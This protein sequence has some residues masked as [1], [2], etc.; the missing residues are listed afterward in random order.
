[1]SAAMAPKL[2]HAASLFI[3][4]NAGDLTIGYR[5]L[6]INGVPR[7]DHYDKN[8]N[9]LLRD[10]QYELKTPVA[11]IH[12]DGSPFLAI[13]TG[14]PEPTSE[15]RLMPHV[16][17]LVPEPFE[18]LLNLGK[19]D[20]ADRAIGVSFLQWAVRGTLFTDRRLW[21]Q[22]RG[23]YS[24]TPLPAPDSSD[25]DIYP[26]FIWNVVLLD[27]TRLALTIDVTSRFV[28]RSWVTERISRRESL[29]GRNCLYQFG[30]QWYLIQVRAVLDTSI[31]TYQIWPE[32]SPHAIGLFQ[33]VHERWRSNPP[34]WIQHLDPKSPTLLFR[35][36]ADQERAAPAGLCK[37][38]LPT[39]DPNAGR[40]L[41]R[42]I[43]SPAE[44]FVRIQQVLIDHL[45]RL[46]L[47]NRAVSLDGPECVAGRY[48]SI[49][50]HR[51]GGNYVMQVD[52]GEP[53]SAAT[54][55]QT[56]N[57]YARRRLQIARNP[58]V[59]PVDRTP[60]G[61]QYLFLPESLPRQINEDFAGR[62]E[63]AVGQIAGEKYRPTRVLY[64]DPGTASLSRQVAAIR[65]AIASS[66]AAHGYALVVLPLNAHPDLH[67]YLKR[68]LWPGL[69]LQCAMAGKIRSHYSQ[70]GSEWV[71]NQM[72][73]LESYVLNCALGLM[74]VNRKWLW[75]LDTPLHY[76][77]YIGIDVL[78][79][80]VGLTFL[81]S[82]GQHVVFSNH[83]AK[84]K[85]RLSSRQIRGLIR[86]RLR[87]DL[88]N[89]GLRPQSIVVHR[90]GRAFDSEIRGFQL[91]LQDLALDSLID[92]DVLSGVVEIRKTSSEGVRLVRRGPDG[93]W[94]N[95]RVGTY[96]SLGSNAGV[97]CTT[98][99]PFS[100]DGTVKPLMVRIADGALDLTHVLHDIFRLSQLAFT[101]PDKCSRLPLTIKLADDFLEPIAGEADEEE[102]EYDDDE[103]IQTQDGLA[104]RAGSESAGTGIKT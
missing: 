35:T 29:R 46:E 73:R 10:T 21:S 88:P 7:D 30:N 104:T 99:A 11:L 4:R 85:E 38:V 42:A 57:S 31:D 54:D 55:T 28:D 41:R 83:A 40:L 60:L 98:G 25:V 74:V 70:N 26:G 23:Y 2:D 68:T 45:S 14:S 53:S 102:A 101:A 6:R 51:F 97:V 19:M 18:H 77:V 76:D 12:R 66:G 48:F 75:C 71:P 15:R 64:H 93:V 90:D 100:F 92:P 95:P 20:A 67:N 24:K 3:V 32:G 86:D 52:D 13:P 84:Q 47:D 22:G 96:L 82:G 9:R 78:N 80:M 44:R 50:A 94:V 69:Q 8:L 49:P 59:G 5:L 56:L 27:D 63:R 72:G 79:Q 1:M 58:N 89:L 39:S 61:P 36:G 91:A 33:Y 37:L 43:L 34:A 17:V 62:L 65:S 103:M 16:A 81:Y 87:V